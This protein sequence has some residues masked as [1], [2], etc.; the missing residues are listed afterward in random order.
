MQ[1][2]EILWVAH[3]AFS[4][5]P[6]P[7]QRAR[8][9]E[10]TKAFFAKRLVPLAVKI[11]RNPKAICV[12][13]KTPSKVKTCSQSSLPLSAKTV[14]LQEVLEQTEIELER[15]LRTIF[16]GKVVSVPND[17]AYS[18]AEAASIVDAKLKARQWH[19]LSRTT[20]VGAGQYRKLCVKDFPSQF[21]FQKNVRFRESRKHT[22]PERLALKPLRQ[23]MARP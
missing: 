3:P 18:V 1:V 5:D 22:L 2:E 21:A 7:D 17:A 13:Q 16:G 14:Q 11:A 4:I 15:Q 9:P 23:T 10:H 19:T 20:I 8:S 6:H 12:L